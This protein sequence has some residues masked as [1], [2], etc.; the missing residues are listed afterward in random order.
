MPQRP[1]KQCSGRGK[2]YHNCRNL[3]KG[4]ERYCPRCNEIYERE[5][6]VR[7][8]RYDKERDQTA[9][10]KF[11]HSTQWRKIRKMKLA[12]DPLCEMCL[13]E[14]MERMACL[15]HHCD[16]NELNNN[17]DNLV[18]VCTPH[19]EAVHNRKGGWKQR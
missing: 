2:Y 17:W 8:R 14:G 9:E 13:K 6:K 5:Q 4:G 1:S 11:I 15:V 12:Q 3:A 7:S 10:R 16:E 18:S 19:H